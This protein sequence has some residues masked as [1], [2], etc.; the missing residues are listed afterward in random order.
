M[1]LTELPTHSTDLTFIA[2]LWVGVNRRVE[3]RRAR[4]IQELTEILTEDW[5]NTSQSLC[6]DVMTSKPNRI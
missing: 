5:T 2:N 6:S 1:S 4:S 3:L